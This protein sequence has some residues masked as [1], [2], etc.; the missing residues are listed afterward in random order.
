MVENTKSGD[1]SG[2]NGG[3]KFQGTAK[4]GTKILILSAV[5]VFV[6]LLGVFFFLFGQSIQSSSSCD[7]S[8]GISCDSVVISSNSSNDSL[9][10]NFVIVSL[11][12][13]SYKPQ[14]ISVS[15]SSKEC[16]NAQIDSFHDYGLGKIG[17]LLN[18]TNGSVGSSVDGKINLTYFLGSKLFNK[19]VNF[20]SKR[21][22]GKDAYK[23]FLNS[24]KE[25]SS[26]EKTSS[27]TEG[28]KV[29]NSSLLSNS[30]DE[31]GAS[32]PVGSAGG[33]SSGGGGGAGGSS[34]SSPPGN[35]SGNVSAILSV[36]PSTVYA[37]YSVTLSVS[38]SENVAFDVYYDGG[39]VKSC[40]SSC[41]YTISSPTQGT[42]TFEVKTTGL[43][44]EHT[45]SKLVDA[46]Q[47][48]YDVSP[49][50]ALLPQNHNWEVVLRNYMA[51]L[52]ESDFQVP[53]EN[54]SWDTSWSNGQSEDQMY[55]WWIGIRGMGGPDA[56]KEIEMNPKYLTLSYIEGGNGN[57]SSIHMRI[58]RGYYSSLE[59]AKWANF[60]FPGN[61]YYNNTAVKLRALIPAMVDLMELTKWHEE[62]YDE[63]S[64]YAGGN[65]ITYAYAY[66]VGKDVLPPAVQQAYEQ[67]VLEMEDNITSWG[68]Y[69]IFGDMDA[70]PAVGMWY[71]AKSSSN[72]EFTTLAQDYTNVIV[73]RWFY[74]SGYFGHGDAFDTS[75]NGLDLYFY[76]WI[77]LLSNDITLKN[78]LAKAFLLKSYLTV[79]DPNSITYW[80]GPSHWDTAT[81]A[82][83]STD[84]WADYTRDVAGTMISSNAD[85]LLQ[86]SGVNR[87][88]GYE[89]IPMP[90][91]MSQS[92]YGMI[93]TAQINNHDV[94][95][96]ESINSYIPLTW[97][98]SHWINTLGSN[99]YAYENYVNGFYPEVLSLNQT[100]SDLLVA[101]FARSG[102]FI[103][104]FS[105]N[106][107]NPTTPTFISAKIGNFGAIVSNANMSWWSPYSNGALSG[108]NGGALSTFWTPKTGAVIN[109]VAGGFQNDNSSQVDSW[110]NWRQWSV[111][112]IS[113]LTASGK[114]FSA[115][116]WRYPTSSSVKNGDTS[117]TATSSGYISSTL[118]FGKTAPNSALSG[119]VA[120]TRDFT[121]NSTGVTITSSISSNGQDQ[122][123]ELWEMIPIYVQS[124]MYKDDI[125]LGGDNATT[126]IYF[127]VGGNWQSG[128]TTLTSN[129]Q[130][131]RLD[132][133]DGSAIIKFRTPQEIKLSSPRH[134][135][136]QVSAWLQNVMID[137]LPTSGNQAMPTSASVTYTISP[138]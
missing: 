104:V 128:S 13:S 55:Q 89:E 125:W 62:G 96:A 26:V 84:Q 54:L 103:K 56:A 83:V 97:E 134:I 30:S 111:N 27:D 100:A 112:T 137:M 57:D 52:N 66:Y 31:S 90:G 69:G 43:S 24:F 20:S 78:D 17:I 117:I 48:P 138:N 12:S 94:P 18:C 121:I 23:K 75:Y 122:V 32:G 25:N 85:Y 64:D 107:N 15:I 68:P 72:P 127:E 70:F 44:E 61:P 40:Q 124:T 81:S 71:M 116:R 135:S 76:E 35:L 51:T 95:F 6:V 33:S 109:G 14:N 63:R 38:L 123:S 132:R 34:G 46:T 8:Q 11:N 41:N 115:A 86:G 2:Q 58:G 79:P 77:E 101:P 1:F 88:F 74:N 19:L 37:G 80:N 93:Y 7:T 136:Y 92:I 60:N 47:N 29:S 106:S 102:N 114:P 98:E 45:W 53:V 119:N 99:I 50:S 105:D 73:N 4:K 126:K 42:H 108:L 16:N 110:N 120:Y 28:H 65:L 39:K 49:Q 130:A 5:L 9:G 131:V 118:D 87:D 91:D 67:G 36:N 10:N 59:A 21:I 3:S 82:P 133:F 22:S 129:V 113:G